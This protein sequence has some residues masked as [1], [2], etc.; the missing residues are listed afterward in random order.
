MT[1][2]EN[3]EKDK[4]RALVAE[5]KTTYEDATDHQQRPMSEVAAALEKEFA[6]QP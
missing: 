6:A 4:A 3:G 5:L 1:L 2:W